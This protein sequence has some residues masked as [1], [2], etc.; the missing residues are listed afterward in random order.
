M[1]RTPGSPAVFNSL[2]SP[3]SD[4]L[5]Q[6]VCGDSLSSRRA[7]PL[8]RPPL[9]TPTE[10]WE[11][12]AQIQVDAECH[13]LNVAGILAP[14]SSSPLS[15]FCNITKIESGRAEA[16]KWP[17]CRQP[18]KARADQWSRL[19][20]QPNRSVPTPTRPHWAIVL[21]IRD[22]V[23]GMLERLRGKNCAATSS[24]PTRAAFSG[25]GGRG[26]VSRSR[27]PLYR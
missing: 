6:A 5:G 4:A 21:D 1:H 14:H 12:P 26:S 16:S 11:G 19:F 24:P 8:I 18:K 10:A 13:P 7:M 17:H 3:S 27:G 20:S 23:T 25:L 2:A 9:G 15:H 22:T